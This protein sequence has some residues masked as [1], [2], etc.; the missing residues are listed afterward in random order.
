MNT[1]PLSGRR[2][3]GTALGDFRPLPLASD[4]QAQAARAEA[5]ALLAQANRMHRQAKEEADRTVT[6]ARTEAQRLRDEARA[7]TERRAKRDDSFDTWA[8]R[9]VIA[10]AVGLTASGEYSLARMVGFDGAVAWLL[11]FV[12]DVYVIQAFRRHRDIVPAI[13]LTITANVIY[14]LAD[15][16][17]FGLSPAGR[18]AWWLIALVASVASLILWRM[19]QMVT[20]PKA[21]RE[22]RKRRRSESQQAPVESPRESESVPVSLSP[23]PAPQPSRESAPSPLVRAPVKVRALPLPSPVRASRGTVRRPSVRVP[24][25]SRPSATS[26]VRP[27]LSSL[28]C[29]SAATPK[30]SASATP[31]GSP[32][33]PTRPPP[34]GSQQPAPSTAVRPP[35]TSRRGTDP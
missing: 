22:S 8:A 7:E 17:L 14:H 30:R 23:P 29:E 1:D 5:E 6:A 21:S 16:G 27:T 25:R 15:A 10:G 34:D 12:I 9:A 11:P 32:A 2:V 24:G 18:P 4:D 26:T 28:S 31:S 33:R 20:P 3:N 13:G 19:H 35:P